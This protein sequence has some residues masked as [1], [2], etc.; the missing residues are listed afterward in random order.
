V[1]TRGGP[2]PSAP[3]WL[4]IAPT[5]TT[6]LVLVS[7]L[8]LVLRGRGVDVLYARWVTHNAPVAL[9]C[10][11]LGTMVLRR[12]PGHRSGAL[13][14][15]LGSASA[16]HVAAISLADA[17]LV[18]A[19]VREQ[20]S[21][22]V[23]F[24]PADLPL[25][26]AVPMWASS[27]LWLVAALPAITL[28]LLI[29]P[30]GA[31]P[32]TRWRWVVPMAV[33]STVA[34]VV[35]YAIE[36][37]PTSTVTI[38]MRGQVSERPLATAIASAAGVLVVVAA[39][40]SVASFVARWRAADDAE[41]HQIRPMAFAGT[42]LIAVFVV[43][44]PW[45]WLW[46]PAGMVA[47]W[48][49]L[50]TYALGIVRYRL[51]DLDVVVNRAVV[52]AVLAAGA[53]AAYL[54]IVVGA[55]AIAGRGRD[56]TLVPLLAAGVVAVGFEPARRRTR[57]LVDRLLYGRDRDASQ[58]LSDLADRLRASRSAEDVLDEVAGLLVRSTGADRVEITMDVDGGDHPVAAHGT[59]ADGASPL[60]EVP[61]IHVD[62]TLGRIRLWARARSDLAPDADELVDRVAS[63][64]GVVL[65]NAALTAELEAQV[66]ELRVSRLRLVRAQDEARRALERD[67]HDGA[68]A[69][70]VAL[71]IKLGIAGSLADAGRAEAVRG[72]LDELGV[73]VDESVRALRALGRGL[74]PP[75]L[76]GAG[77]G[78]ALRAEARILPMAVTVQADGLGRYDPA[79]EAA[80]YFSCL[81]AIQNAAKHGRARHVAVHLSNGGEDLAFSVAD[82]GCGF[83][84]A[85]T[86]AG[87]GLT[88]MR[89]RIGSLG[90][91]FSLEASPGRGVR[92]HGTVPALPVEPPAE[93]PDRAGAER[94]P[95]TPGS[96][97]V[98]VS[99]R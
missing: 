92:V 96:P 27:W 90:G 99:E 1:G 53:T 77:I 51:H 69:R 70:L 42:G 89:D 7:V 6:V 45:Q 76:E 75:V 71:R 61:V 20:G 5:A 73:E 68:Q 21:E 43:T 28:L 86:P 54:A 32:G 3:R 16:L 24:A 37:W 46:I 79:V 78:A 9:V 11:W 58:V 57:Q 87:T 98:P 38:Q 66:A 23:P 72:L 50:G 35:A 85:R 36:T 25:D 4:R 83:D 29:F 15:L 56:S 26:A 80:V 18:A 82:D 91:R 52:A 88:N 17:R 30:T 63:T 81:E 74:H 55:G 93:A 19:G 31:P 13:L 14:V 60:V 10:V 44:F 64:L 33:T 65:H 34:M 2:D 39:T 49:F 97:Q 40:G 94:W 59:V 62:E 48:I 95:R 22:F 41:R 8:T 12:R 47:V 67:I 84:A